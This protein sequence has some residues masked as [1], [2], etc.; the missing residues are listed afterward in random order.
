MPYG[1]SS[2]VKHVIALDIGRAGTR[3]ALIAR[4]GTVLDHMRR[5]SGH[6]RGAQAV[7]EG[8][9]DFIA[10]LRGCG[11]RKYGRRHAASASRFPGLSTR[12]AAWP[13]SPP[14]WAGAMFRCA[15]C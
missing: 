15:P 10:E 14:T 7:A 5:A 2:T 13:C 3:A 6:E 12:A 1:T 9:L 11:L 4:D 8:V